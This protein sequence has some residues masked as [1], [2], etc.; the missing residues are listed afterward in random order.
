MNTQRR[1]YFLSLALA[2]AALLMPAVSGCR[3]PAEKVTLVNSCQSVALD[4]FTNFSAFD[5][6]RA[7]WLLPKGPQVLDGVPFQIVGVVQLAGS[8]RPGG[9]GHQDAPNAVKDIPVN[10]AF[11]RLHLLTAVDGSTDEGAVVARIELLYQ[12]GSSATLNLKYGD[13]VRNW[14][15]P[16]H[17]SERPLRDTN[18][19]VAWVGQCSDAASVDRFPRLFHVVLDNPQPFKT[20]RALSVEAVVDNVGPFFAGITVGPSFPDRETNTVNLPATPF[21]DLRP[22]RGQPA[23]LRGVVRTWGGDPIAGARVEVVSA[24]KFRTNLGRNDESTT[25]EIFATTG[26]DGAFSLPSLPDNRL[27][28]L[29]ISKE[30]RESSEYWGADPKSDPVEIR[31]Q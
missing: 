15:A 28:T 8:G 18:C 26:S 23:D 1:R 10:L 9:Q 20:V 31:L 24:R 4:L 2:G 13:Q 22:R 29:E 19:S 16:W 17:R 5:D 3:K 6:V 25:N 11:E 7:P 30:G 21:P 27:Y 14:T 12:D